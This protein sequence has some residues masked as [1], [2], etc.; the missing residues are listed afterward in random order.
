[1][2]RRV[3]P[4]RNALQ[5]DSESEEEGAGSSASTA[6]PPKKK[7]GLFT[8]GR[9]N[10]AHAVADH[11]DDNADDTPLA[12]DDAATV[13]GA[14]LRRGGAMRGFVPAGFD[15]ERAF[16]E[17]QA[18]A[19]SRRAE[20]ERALDENV[21]ETGGDGDA[22]ELDAYMRTMRR[23]ATTQEPATTAGGAMKVASRLDLD[24]E[25]DAEAKREQRAVEEILRRNAAA[26]AD[27]AQAT[28]G[29]S[30]RTKQDVS[31]NALGAYD[32]DPDPEELYDDDDE[33]RFDARA[34]RAA[35]RN[36]DIEPLP[37]VD[38]SQQEYVPIAS[39][40]YEE[41]HDVA[42]RSDE[43]TRALR[44]RLGVH[45]SGLDVPRPVTSFAHLGL[46]D[47]V[48]RVL[49]RQ[50][51]V[52]PTAV[53]AQTIPSAMLGRDVLA[54]AQTGQGKTLAFVLP[55]V[56]HAAWQPALS[57]GD[58]PL[59]VI[60]APT[61]EL[62]HQIHAEL[63]PFAKA[64]SLTVADLVGGVDKHEQFKVLRSAQHPPHIVVATP[65]RLI[66]LVRMRATNFTRT[67]MLVLDEADRMFE[68]G[69]ERQVRSVCEA[70]RPDRQTMLFSATFRRKV[71]RLAGEVLTDPVRIR[72]G[73]AGDATA[74][75]SAASLLNPGIQHYFSVVQTAADKW[76]WIRENVG[77]M[78]AY[79]GGKTF[80]VFVGKREAAVELAT[81]L[82]RL[83]GVQC[84]ALHGEL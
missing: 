8:F 43:E 72:V 61:H 3:P 55:A 81:N 60:L 12:V 68:M 19:E 75:G 41:H 6:L 26:A 10:D 36:K 62:V 30:A 29:D 76:A 39:V 13:A 47:S 22:D 59:V 49:S 51:M 74:L 38:H 52:E 9:E 11:E 69:F 28:G 14:P 77:K 50:S 35:A 73:S 34:A 25:D 17:R 27:A 40:H 58:G 42:R 15:R 71:E 24:A 31:A 2:M 21:E 82:A 23:E 5:E 65:G 7:L 54:V 66:D 64:L 57:K 16:A 4:R 78:L 32:A 53:Q 80:L 1:M 63:R 45:C 37:F 67:S 46:D 84:L 48:L 20:L 33:D 44:Q 56:L 18:Q 83:T 70:I 79:Y